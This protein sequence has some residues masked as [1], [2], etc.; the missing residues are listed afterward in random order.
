[1]SDKPI[2]VLESYKQ[3]IID[4]LAHSLEQN[5]RVASA[6][7]MQSVDVRIEAFATQFKFTILMEDYWKYVDGGRAKGAKMPPLNAM[8]KH[9]AN[10][11][12]D[13]KRLMNY[14]K[15]KK[16][17]IVKRGKPLS[18][19]KALKQLAFLIGRKIKRT[20]IKPTHFVEEAF[21]TGVIDDMAR[22]ISKALGRE[23][24][25]DLKFKS[26]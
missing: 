8:L 5:D 9:I 11:G 22:D 3:K 7:L 25:L 1:M 26:K 15:N 16:G 12:I 18:K 14:T 21:E 2:D 20:G 10:R 4:A 19:D 13:Y 6:R 24:A 17:V 23:I